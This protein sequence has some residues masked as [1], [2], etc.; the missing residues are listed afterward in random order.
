MADRVLIDTC[1]WARVFAR[2]GSSEHQSVERLIEQD[3]VILIGP[4]LTEVLYG[5]R[6]QEQADWAASRLR[7]LRW[8]DLEWDD[9]RDAA[10][11]GRQLAA[12]GHRL[13][14]TD[15]L[16]A[17]IARRHDLSVHTVD[18]HFDL[19]ADLRRFALD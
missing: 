1:I 11:L 5:F 19:L 9:W 15:L 4:V 14:L 12:G 18:P 16:I 10:A 2:P 8:M 3:R 6:R 17:T 7:N 13:P